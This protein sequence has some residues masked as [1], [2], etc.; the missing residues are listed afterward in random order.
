LAAGLQVNAK[1]LARLVMLPVIPP[2]FKGDPRCYPYYAYFGGDSARVAMLRPGYFHIYRPGVL[3]S[4]VPAPTAVLVSR[5]LAEMFESVVSGGWQRRA[6]TLWDPASS[7]ENHEQH[8]E[9]VVDAEI[10]PDSL[11]KDVSGMKLWR[12]GG[13][14]LFVSPDLMELVKG[15]F[16]D[17]SFS[18]GFWTFL[19]GAG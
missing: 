3:G 6:A 7:T 18:M 4:I 13:R 12:S 8:V 10:G 15:S 11:P 19:G 1:A 16:K 9:L 14:Y 17:V 2:N 5:E